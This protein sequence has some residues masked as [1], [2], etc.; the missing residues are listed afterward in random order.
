MAKDSR[1][2]LQH[3]VAF[4]VTDKEWRTLKRK[5]EQERTTVPQLAKSLLFGKFGFE[6]PKPKRN[7]EGQ[8]M[9]SKPKNS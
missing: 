5:A 9:G 4:R 3:S 1:D 7:F 6:P 2:T 8:R